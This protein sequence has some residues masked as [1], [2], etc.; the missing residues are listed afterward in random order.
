[1]TMTDCSTRQQILNAVIA[2]IDSEGEDQI[3]LAE[4][5]RRC[6]VSTPL[7]YHYFENRNHLVAA[8]MLERYT[9]I[10]LQDTE[11]IAQRAALAKKS[12][13][14]LEASI[15][16]GDEV[17]RVS[18]RQVRW[19]NLEA[20]SMAMYDPDIMEMAIASETEIS[21]ALEAASAML[22]ARGWIRPDVDPRAYGDFWRSLAYGQLLQ[23]VEG[24]EPNDAEEW[25]D[26]I[27]RLFHTFFEIE[28]DPTDAP[29]PAGLGHGI[30]PLPRNSSGSE[31][32]G[33]E[34]NQ[35]RSTGRRKILNAA[36]A[37]I[38]E[39]GV[40]NLRTKVVAEQ[41]GVSVALLFHHFGSREGLIGEAVAERFGIFANHAVHRL[42][43]LLV[44]AVEAEGVIDGCIDVAAFMLTAKTAVAARQEWLEAVVVSRNNEMAR[45]ALADAQKMLGDHLGFFF[46]RLALEGIVEPMVSPK[47]MA[48]MWK[49]LVFGQVIGAVA[50]DLRPSVEN[51]RS[52]LKVA[53]TSLLRPVGV[54]QG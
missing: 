35:K 19:E 53:F 16:L 4:V 51:W 5:A 40:I 54:L 9:R 42:N 21:L 10:V 28:F 48:D 32:E 1:M 37:E 27:S 6:G 34:L 2:I 29:V 20:R 3:R 15:H 13:E 22:S 12:S 50:P 11:F 7:M 47:V 38:A 26:A 14:I 30:A 31:V 18:R 24:S 41:A 33:A 45:L 17:R 46:S 23:E 39:H 43:E 49:A 52:V 25:N 8:A 36:M 44:S